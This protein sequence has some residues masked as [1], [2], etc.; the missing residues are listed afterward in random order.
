MG[1]GRIISRVDDG[2]VPRTAV[3]GGDAGVLDISTEGDCCAVVGL[4]DL[5]AG[6]VGKGAVGVVAGVHLE[7]VDAG[8][9]DDR[10]V[11]KLGLRCGSEEVVPRSTDEGEGIGVAQTVDKAVATFAAED[12]G[13]SCRLRV[14]I[15]GH[16]TGSGEG[17]GGEVGDVAEGRVI[18][19][20][21]HTDIQRVVAT[22]TATDRVAVKRGAVLDGDKVVLTNRTLDVQRKR[23]IP[24]V[25]DG[26]VTRST[27][28]GL[29]SG[30]HGLGSE[31][32][33]ACPF[34]GQH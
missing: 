32:D 29:E 24:R 20:R 15:E 7:G 6:E 1:G 4:E 10:V 17:E 16:R 23:V 21:H 27:V 22:R 12:R 13:K 8:Q 5:D 33:L 11:G 9:S 28:D 19:G 2:V 34:K 14:R 30:A 31:G 3:D 25:G 26:I 18:E